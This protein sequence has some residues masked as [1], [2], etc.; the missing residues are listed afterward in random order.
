MRTT[1]KTMM[2]VVVMMMMIMITMEQKE[3][4]TESQNRFFGC[5]WFSWSLS[6]RPRSLRGRR[7][8]WH[9]R[10]TFEA[11]RYIGNCVVK[12]TSPV[13]FALVS[14]YSI[15]STLLTVFR[16]NTVAFVACGMPKNFLNPT[17]STRGNHGTGPSSRSATRAP[18]VMDFHQEN[19]IVKFLIPFG[20]E[21]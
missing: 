16:T 21:L 14:L 18:C 1:T 7:R 11:P 6:R 2:V 3:L 17:N 13:L 5:R 10:S 4:L 12:T 8:R 20:L 15:I 9:R 19:K